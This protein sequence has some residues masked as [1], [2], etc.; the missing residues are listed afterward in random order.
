MNTD[1]AT[2]ATAPK[3]QLRSIIAAAPDAV[4]LVDRSGRIVLLNALAERLFGYSGDELIGRPVEVLVPER[5]RGRH[6]DLRYRYQEAPTQRAMGSGVELFGRRRDGSEFPA[7]IM[8]SP[9]PPQYGEVIG[10]WVRDTS[11]TQRVLHELRESQAYNRGLIESSVDA[12]ITTDPLGSITD[13]NRMLCEITGYLPEQL[14]GT[15]FSQYFT[16]TARADAAIC[17]VLSENRL[18][19][20]ELTLRA[21]DGREIPVS[22]NAATFRDSEQR[23]KGVFAAARDITAQKRLEE[24]LRQTQHYTRG[25]IEASVEAMLTVDLELHITD[26]NQRTVE[27]TGRGR[28]ELIGHAF[29]AYFTDP[30]RARALLQ[31]TLAQGAVTEALLVMCAGDGREASLSF[32]TAVFKDT[33]GT[34]RGIFAAGR[35]MSARL[36]LETQLRLAQHYTRGLIESSVDAMIVVT[37]ELGIADV[38]RQMEQLTGMPRERLIGSR[39]DSHFTDPERAAAG[40]QR[41]LAEGSVIDCELTMSAAA[42]GGLVVSLNASAFRDPEG[43]VRGIFAVVRDVT[44]QR[45]LERQLRDQGHY[46]RG[47]TE[48]VLDALIMVDTDLLI[49]DVNVQAVRLTGYHAQRL[50]GTPIAP[51]FTDPQR[52]RTLVSQAFASGALTGAE[53]TLRNRSGAETM[54]SFNASVFRDAAGAVAGVLVNVRDISQQ[55]ALEQ[56]LREQ[57]AYCRGLIESSVDALLTTDPLGQLV[58]VNRQMCA[59]TGCTREQ[60]L[61]TP[62][63]DRF[64]D[65]RSAED[66]VRTVLTQGRVRNHE[67]VLRASDGSQTPVALNASTVTGGDGHL[68][69]IF[70]S[71]RDIS[72]RKRLEADLQE[73]RSQVR[74]LLEASADPALSADAELIVSDVNEALLRLTGQTREQLVGVPLAQC[75]ADPEAAAATWQNVIE[76]AAVDAGEWRLRAAQ[77]RELP[78]AVGSAVFRDAG[79]RARGLCI[80]ARDLSEQHR[81]GERLQEQQQ[82]QRALIEA[83]PEAAAQ[84]DSEWRVIEV[85]EALLA[86]CG[87]GREE[88]LGSALPACFSSPDAAAA[89]LQ[90]S[91]LEPVPPTAELVLRTAA[92]R[93]LRVVCRAGRRRTA[94]GQAGLLVTIRDVTAQQRLQDELL[95]QQAYYR[96]LIESWVDALMTLDR[97]GRITDVNGQAALFTGYPREQLIGSLFQD[98]FT[99]PEQALAAIGESFKQGRLVHRELL[100]RGKDG[101][102]RPV[103]FDAGVFRDRGGHVAGIL[104]ATRDIAAQK[105]VE[106]EL[107]EQ[108]AYTRSL[109]D[110]NVDA[111]LTTDPLGI[112]TDVNARL[113]EITGRDRAQ[114]IGRP[115]RDCFSEPLRAQS[116]IRTVLS[117]D[118]LINYELRLRARDDQEILVSCNASTLRSAR[119]QLRGVLVALRD[120]SDQKDLE[121]QLTQRNAELTQTTGLLDNVLQSSTE[122]SIIALDLDGRILTWNE[123]ARLGYGYTA[124]E[125]VGQ[126]HSAWLHAPEDVA[127]GRV[128]ALFDQAFSAGKAE[129][130]FERRHRDGH[131]FT[132]SVSMTLRRD[133]AGAPLGYLLIAKDITEQQRL[134]A[135]LQRKNEQLADQYLRLQEANRLKSEFLANM[136]HE[137]RTPLNAIIGFSELLFDGKVGELVPEHH[138]FIGDILSS[139][140]HLLQ[141]INEVLDLAKVEAGMMK[142]LP[143]AVELDKL[144]GEVRDV[145]STITAQRRVRVL[146]DIDPSVNAIVADAG[147]LKQVLYNY[148][149]NALKFSPD[150]GE[151]TIRARPQDAG[152]FRLEVEDHG[153]GIRTEDLPRLFQEFQQIDD[154]VARKYRGTGLGLSLTRRIVEAQGGEVGVRS[155]PGVGSVFFAVLPTAP[156]TE[157]AAASREAK[158]K[159][160]GRARGK[161]AAEAPRVLVVEGEAEERGWLTRTLTQAG[162][163]VE[164]AVTGAGACALCRERGYDAVA[165]DLALPD[166]SGWDLLRSLRKLPRHAR[167]P[168]VALS[169]AGEAVLQSA[170]VISDHL[171]KPVSAAELQAWLR[172]AG[173]AAG[174]GQRVAV[175]DQD[176]G[177]RRHFDELLQESGYAPVL[178]GSGAE[179][180][181]FLR[182]QRPQALILDQHIVEAAGFDALRGLRAEEGGRAPPLL[183]CAEASLRRAP[184]RRQAPSAVAAA[185]QQGDDARRLIAELQR[186]LSPRRGRSGERPRPA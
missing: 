141:L 144:V 96:S 24:Q 160:R 6:R 185:P 22:F 162:Y 20:C 135:E 105:Q 18:S 124:D 107:R 70:A 42:D 47:L 38:N 81:L 180:Q 78:V 165:F 179:L 3:E 61:D 149:S 134:E 110:Y 142:F 44:A 25:L 148:L 111:L 108:H 174:A 154:A 67:L 178:L 101:R 12:L 46:W 30:P 66:A 106:N 90:R 79:G 27:L 75:F 99:E 128:Q 13:V 118:R 65:A 56:Q 91:L 77:G 117:E 176:A 97:R 1:V 49:A 52:A 181:D 177:A 98:Y 54:V 170:L 146:V 119:G 153:T 68:R 166:Q 23:L 55:K 143:E 152:R 184:Q 63:K 36:Q 39:F 157:K 161:A 86:L 127:S 132:A 129:G 37:T 145:L 120:I 164:T 109:I 95:E 186:S 93:S 173:V 182:Q 35:D 57:Q 41:T 168:A 2:V 76:G 28:D 183:V 163:R 114:L 130:V 92:A 26:V 125:M 31:Q 64:S 59:L 94:D 155:E 136:S 50:I 131:R 9:L 169:M 122:Y 172:R 104:V 32:N 72:A 126:G 137:L 138:E 88:L 53:L 48:A 113:C 116:G 4:V 17:Q 150:A 60:L 175:V 82:Q 8:L 5:F 21:R 167:T 29:A 33:G 147:K 159:P 112:V 43:Q 80:V 34:L 140:R 15:S 51:Y 133:A 85:N 14:L 115:F 62:F 102:L 69:G 83:V 40:V 74:A 19:D 71:V 87:R 7:D 45:Q 121:E 11:E 123:G 58:D 100:L 158:A 171:L 73:S 139:A 89:H 16:D 151:V 84:L 103:S 10:A 156:Q